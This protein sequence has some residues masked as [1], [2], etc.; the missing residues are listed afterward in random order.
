MYI[1]IARSSRKRFL[2]GWEVHPIV[3]PSI[4]PEHWT[5]QVLSYLVNKLDFLRRMRWHVLPTHPFWIPS[6]HAC[7]C[8]SRHTGSLHTDPRSKDFNSD[9]F[10]LQIS[11]EKISPKSRGDQIPQLSPIVTKLWIF[12]CL[13]TPLHDMVERNVETG[14]WT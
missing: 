2:W 9:V 11:D 14:N 8:L 13:Y 10:I 5:P 3:E 4:G 7:M 6:H 12:A 1:Q